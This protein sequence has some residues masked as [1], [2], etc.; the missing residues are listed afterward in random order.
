MLRVWCARRRVN[1]ELRV[2]LEWRQDTWWLRYRDPHY[3]IRAL[4]P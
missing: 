4:A 3:W 2:G 1:E